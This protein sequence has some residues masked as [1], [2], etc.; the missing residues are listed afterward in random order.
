MILAEVHFE[1]S[2]IDWKV[3]IAALAFLVALFTLVYFQWWRNRRR[4]SYEILSDVVLV[5]PDNI[6]DKVEI[7][8]EGKMVQRVH[9]VV[10]KLIN[11]GYQPIKKDDFQKSVKFLFTSGKILAAEKVEFEPKNL[12]TKISHEED[13]VEVAPALFNRKDYIKFKVLLKWLWR[14]GH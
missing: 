9:L 4:L 1:F 12:D 8:Y 7:R 3:V 10:V 6:V 11:D 13:S 2:T 5:S 14:H